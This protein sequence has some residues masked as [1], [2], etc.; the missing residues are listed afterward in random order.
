MPVADRRK[1]FRSVPRVIKSRTNENERS[2]N[3]D[4]ESSDLVRP[5]L[6]IQKQTN[7]NYNQITENDQQKSNDMMAKHTLST[8]KNNTGEANGLVEDS[9][10][11][12]NNKNA[13]PN[14]SGSCSSDKNLTSSS[15]RSSVPASSVSRSAA[16][17][18]P[19]AGILDERESERFNRKV[20]E[21]VQKRLSEEMWNLYENVHKGLSTLQNSSNE[22]N[23]LPPNAP[24]RFESADT[25]FKDVLPEFTFVTT[26][27][28]E[29]L[30]PDSLCQAPPSNQAKIPEKAS[31]PDK[32][33]PAN[34]D[35]VQKD[36]VII[37]QN[38]VTLAHDN[39]EG[40]I[41]D[42]IDT[43]PH[44]TIRRIR[45]YLRERLNANQIELRYRGRV[46]NN[47]NDTLDDTGW[48]PGECGT[49]TVRTI[50]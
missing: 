4:S 21:E 1:V 12:E 6:V 31:P 46:L 2:E 44:L 38:Q 45:E 26:K 19:V 3:K 34:E 22:I 28:D 50:N 13:E 49:I 8:N 40:T 32:T 36:A 7:K 10:D 18:E 9:K 48:I 15:L 35:V 16:P 14:T 33:Q 24:P 39:P 17:A 41:I 5:R 11:Q 42:K 30:V 47:D 25:F 27:I 37:A 23:F 20:A 43:E 29:Q